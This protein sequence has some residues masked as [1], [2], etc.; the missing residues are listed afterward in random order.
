VIALLALPGLGERPKHGT[1]VT[2][3][4]LAVTGP[5]DHPVWAREVRSSVVPVACSSWRIWL[6][7][8]ARLMPIWRECAGAAE[9]G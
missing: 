9:V 3:E 7:R 8:V 5:G 2:G 1:D 6:S 4:L